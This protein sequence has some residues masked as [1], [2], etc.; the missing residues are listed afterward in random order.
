MNDVRRQILK[1]LEALSDEYPDMRFG[2]LVINVSN[3]AEQAPDALWDLE[4]EQLLDAARRHLAR[5]T[6]PAG[7]P[8]PSSSGLPAFP[9][10]SQPEHGR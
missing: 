5:R 7:A 2:Q 1:V 3:W 10:P 9:S 6:Q 8:V 4:D